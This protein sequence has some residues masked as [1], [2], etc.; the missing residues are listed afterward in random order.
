M[1][2]FRSNFKEQNTTLLWFMDFSCSFQ[3]CTPK[4]GSS[5]GQDRTAESIFSSC[6]DMPF[7]RK[8]KSPKTTTM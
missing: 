3:W 7:F 1:K 5:N 6:C 2:K 4:S 8:N